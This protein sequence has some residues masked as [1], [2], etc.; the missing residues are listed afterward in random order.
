M[1]YRADLDGLRAVAV[2][3]V[4][5][6]HAR[7]PVTNDGGTTGVTAFFVLSGYLITR[8]LATELAT[9][10]RI[11]LRAFYLRRVLR[12]GPALVLLLVFVA[13]IGLWVGWPGDWQVGI[14]ASLLY[15]GNWV[16]VA[17]HSIE[18]LGHTWTLAI[19]EQFYLLWP[20]LLVLGGPRVALR[21]AVAGVVLGAIAGLAADGNLEYFSTITRG[22]AILAGC[23]LGIVQPTA[24]RFVGVAGMALLLAV[25]YLNL[26]HDAATPLSIL[27]S[28]MIISSSLPVLGVLAPV[29]RRAYG[30]YLWNWP[31]AILFGPLGA[32]L[33]F[34]AAALSYRLVERPLSRRYGPSLHRAR[35]EPAVETE[36]VEPLGLPG[37]AIPEPTT[38]TSA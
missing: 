31:M 28:G 27:A 18:P 37:A 20:V 6:T 13:V 26:S 24:S 8:L 4:I 29:G 7:F 30:L 33:T 34:P 36:S 10:G 16:Q 9:F 17:G 2:V 15:V 11:D 12:L 35:P 19:E 32:V 1:K 25:T 22:D 3:L 38:V 23:V 21:V 5:L 14:V